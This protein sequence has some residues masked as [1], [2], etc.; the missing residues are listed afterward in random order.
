VIRTDAYSDPVTA[1]LRLLVKLGFEVKG[2]STGNDRRESG[3]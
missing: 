2:S 1:T 3:G